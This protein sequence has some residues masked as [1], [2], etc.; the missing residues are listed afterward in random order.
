MTRFPEQISTVLGERLLDA[1]IIASDSG[2]GMFGGA[3]CRQR[4]GIYRG[5]GHSEREQDAAEGS[6]PR[7]RQPVRQVW[8]GAV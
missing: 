4:L 2:V 3:G 7:Q 6:G 8:R 5:T 1:K